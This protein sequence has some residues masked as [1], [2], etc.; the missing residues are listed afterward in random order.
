MSI[1]KLLAP[2]S[3]TI[4]HESFSDEVP[5]VT[6]KE[7][8]SQRLE[9]SELQTVVEDKVSNFSPKQEKQV[10]QN[11]AFND[12]HTDAKG[13]SN[14][15]AHINVRRLSECLNITLQPCNNDPVSIYQVKGEDTLNF[16]YNFVHYQW[17]SDS[18]NNKQT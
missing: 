13:S 10:I 18:D 14:T 3:G 2:S 12:T 15:D 17:P 6:G 11:V 16:I 5:S 4:Q 1:Q 7:C 8:T 9:Y